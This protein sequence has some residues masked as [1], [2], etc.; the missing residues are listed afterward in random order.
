AAITEWV[1]RGGVLVLM[2]N[3]AGNAEFEHFNQLAKPFGIQFNQ[4]SKNRVQGNDFPAGSVMVPTGHPIFKT[5]GQLYLKELSTLVVAS[6]AKAVMQHK[7]DV[8]MATA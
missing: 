5:A 4:D 1:K 7:G 6:P 8:I 2:G 3:D